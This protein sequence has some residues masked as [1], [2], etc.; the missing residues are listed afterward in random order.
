VNISADIEYADY[1]EAMARFIREQGAIVPKALRFEGRQLAARLVKFTPPRTL[2]Q[3]KKAVAR[4]IKRAVRPLRSRDFSSKAIR[5]LIRKKDHA[6]LEAVFANFPQTSDLHGV[7][8]V[9]PDFP[10][11]HEEVRDRRGRVKRFQGR[12][13]PDAG[14]VRDYIGTIQARVGRGRSGWAISL[15]ALSGRTSAWVIRHGSGQTGRFEDRL[16]PEGY[17][18]MENRSEWADQGDEDR[19]VANAIRSRAKSVL[20]ALAKAQGEAIQKAKLN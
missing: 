12:V 3:G 13:S 7:A 1:A 2:S 19:I 17:L 5:K 11:M 10:K 4:D 18:R 14:V 20:N 9:E 8:V 15:L 6:A 16:K